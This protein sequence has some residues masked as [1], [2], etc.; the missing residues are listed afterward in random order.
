LKKYNRFFLAA[1]LVVSIMFISG[2]FITPSN[3]SPP[4]YFS[5]YYIPTYQED[6]YSV[7]VSST[8]HD[9]GI[10]VLLTDLGNDSSLE[11]I[12]GAD[13]GW[14][15]VFNK[16]DNLNLITSVDIRT[17]DMTL[18]AGE[19]KIYSLAA[20]DINNSPLTQEILVGVVGHVSVLTWTGS[21]FT[22][23][24]NIELNNDN[25]IVT[26]VSIEDI[27][28]DGKNEIIAASGNAVYTGSS[29]HSGELYAWLSDQFETYPGDWSGSNSKT[30]NRIFQVLGSVY[31]LFAY[32]AITGDPDNDGETEIIGYFENSGTGKKG[33]MIIS[34]TFSIEWDS[35]LQYPFNNYGTGYGLAVGD[36]N[37]DGKN[38]LITGGSS[39]NIHVFKSS[40]EASYLLDK[41]LTI[42][43]ATFVWGLKVCDTDDDSR[44][45]LV[46]TT[47]EGNLTI[48]QGDASNILPENPQIG[49]I[50]AQAG[51]FNHIECYD[52][53]DDSLKELIIGKS[54]PN[55]GL[56]FLDTDNNSILFVY[57][58]INSSAEVLVDPPSTPIIVGTFISFEV[59]YNRTDSIPPQGITTLDQAKV[60]NNQTENSWVV[61]STINN[62]GG[63]YT[64][65]VSTTG[66]ASGEY[67]LK[68]ILIRTGFVP[69]VVYV[70]LNI[71]GAPTIISIIS[72]ADNSSGY[73][74]TYNE[75]NPYVNDDEKWIEFSFRE[76]V[77]FN[78]LIG[79]QVFAKLKY[80][81]GSQVPGK[82]SLPW[83]NMFLLS[84]GNP[85]FRGVYRANIDATDIHVGNYTLNIIVEQEGYSGSE[86][87]VIVHVEPTP[88]ELLVTENYIK[89]FRGEMFTLSS[90]FYDSFLGKNIISG[91]I[92]YELVNYSG[93]L[94]HLS[95]GFYQTE[96][97]TSSLFLNTGN[98][99]I[100]LRATATDYEDAEYNITL[101]YNLK[102]TAILRLSQ[103]PGSVLVG[104]GYPILATLTF[105]NSTPMANKP[106][107]FFINAN[108][109]VIER[110]V[111][112][113]ENGIAE[114]DVIID[115]SWQFVQISAVFEGDS[116]IETTGI[117]STVQAS[118][119]SVIGMIVGYLPLVGLG[120]AVVAGGAAGYYYLKVIPSRRKKQD[121]IKK[122]AEVFNNLTNI[123]HVMVLN[124][125][126]GLVIYERSFTEEPLDS[127]LI[128]G[129]IQAISSFGTEIREKGKR[130]LRQL[131]YEDFRILAG[132][133]AYIRTA[134]I[135]TDKPTP[136]LESR[137]NLFTQVFE[138]KFDKQLKS[139]TGDR[140]SFFGAFEI[141]DDIFGFS[142]MLPQKISPEYKTT[143]GLTD[144]QKSLIKLGEEL[145]KKKG[146]FY[147]N[148]LASLAITLRKEDKYEILDSIYSLSRKKLF[149]PIIVE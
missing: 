41:T 42:S 46:S 58:Y 139:W 66:K 15:Y 135:L 133:G 64:I 74:E 88:S 77:S 80:S 12:V 101:N 40:S 141:I 73:W 30:R 17:L 28:E 72:G 13:N 9:A 6:N 19:A 97:D 44:C 120:A 59:R 137:I 36:V 52:I 1:I 123:Q 84:G 119:T 47:A 24:Q 71:T 126:N 98:H 20:G 51:S 61:N 102:Y 34:N 105:S 3:Q 149:I 89:V 22:F 93:T 8:T 130:K 14:L 109:L 92:V 37:Q 121:E 147:I 23:I 85:L 96:V 142:M 35:T 82:E 118:V 11:I 94:D 117:I 100:T 7:G 48:Y 4:Q 2:L 75:T 143:Y 86:I 87:D 55:S 122:N 25:N 124:K 99:T 43:G 67:T 38:E 129:F 127:A 148:E 114:L 62:G 5:D 76:D 79:A 70:N 145:A 16:S 103:F 108:G 68:V 138:E 110:I 29:P 18:T 53:D 27:N 21:G 54:G 39:G 90:I 65:E 125:K 83:L 112:T 115:E 69:G 56:G 81:D 107:S 63:N 95:F 26:S 33:I 45:E 60:V 131:D 116:E 50:G 78:P 134:L 146:Y 10:P 140:D 31:T 132:E 128:G 104:Q 49:W 91:S 106:I 136:T 111:D 32:S 113:D 144:L 57:G